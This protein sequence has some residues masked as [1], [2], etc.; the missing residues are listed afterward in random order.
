[1]IPHISRLFELW[2]IAAHYRLD[3]ILQS[4]DIPTQA[5]PLIKLINLH[6]A[7]WSNKQLNNPNK[8]KNALEDMGPLAIK[9]GQLLSTRRDLIPPDII[10]QLSTLQDQVKP[11]AVDVLKAR[12]Q[13]SLKADLDTLFKRFDQQPLAAASIAQ[14]HTA[15]LHDGREVIVK[16]TRPHIKKQLIQDFEILIWLSKHIETHLVMAR[17][18]QLR[19]IIQDYRQ[20]ILNEL[21]LTLEASNTRR[22]RKY[23]TGS[24]MMYVPEVYM[25]STDVMVAERI[26]GVSIADTETLDQLNIDR[27]RLAENGLK[28]F[29]TQVLRDNFFHADMHPGNIFIETLD[30][31]SPRHI[32]L[33]CAIMGELSKQDQM[34]VTRMLLAVMNADFDQLVQII[35]QAAWVPANTDQNALAREMC[36]TVSPML[37]KPMNELDFAGILLQIMDIA[38]R[39]HLEIPPQLMLLIKTLVHVEGLGTALYPQLDIWTLAQPILNDW[40]KSNTRPSKGLKYIRQQLPEIILNAQALPNALTTYLNQATTQAQ[41]QEQQQRDM[42]NMRLDLELQHKRSWIFGSLIAIVLSIAV[43][44]PWF[45]ALPLLVCAMILVLWRLVK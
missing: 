42:Q 34:Y 40:I 26:T 20:T 43:M 39:F 10:N 3:T 44:T 31:P 45:I 25:D 14:V 24:D 36:R 17:V 23:F 29:F 6:P 21:D 15:A 4:D 22:M 35:T 27:K 38:R 41:W 1:M 16:V 28:I 30:T 13:H 11:Y 8:L 12:I 32:A 33:D 18:L 19:Q 7:A 2:R 37:D 5:K 9:L